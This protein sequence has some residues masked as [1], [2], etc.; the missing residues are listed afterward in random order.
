VS[1]WTGF[2][3]GAALGVLPALTV[4]VIYFGYRLLGLHV[5]PGHAEGTHAK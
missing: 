3:L 4:A 2:Y 5:C 1:F